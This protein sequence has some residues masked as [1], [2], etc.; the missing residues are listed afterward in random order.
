MKAETE[1]VLRLKSGT[2]VTNKIG[3]NNGNAS[4]V[5][6]AT[7]TGGNVALTGITGE[8]MFFVD[9]GTFFRSAL[10][11]GD[12][13][14]SSGISTGSASATATHTTTVTVEK[15]STEYQNYFQQTF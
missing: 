13:Q 6:V 3:D 11:S 1:A 10:T 4:A 15:G 2:K 12:S 9:D 7:P 5:F 14:G 8:N